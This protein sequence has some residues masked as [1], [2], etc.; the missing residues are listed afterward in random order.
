MIRVHQIT[1]SGW[2][3]LEKATQIPKFAGEMGLWVEL[4]NPGQD[5]YQQAAD[6][7]GLDSKIRL[8]SCTVHLV[9]HSKSHALISMG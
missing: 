6:A 3:T 8:A 9:A 4:L 7:L 2:E 1:E 5:E